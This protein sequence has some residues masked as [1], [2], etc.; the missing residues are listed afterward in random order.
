MFVL[1]EDAQQ[2]AHRHCDVHS[3]KMLL[4]TVQLLYS[5][6]RDCPRPAQFILD[7][8]KVTHRNHPVAMWVRSSAPAYNWGLQYA[9]ALLKE[10]QSRYKKEHK[11][12]PHIAQ[13]RA[14]GVPP[15]V[16]E[17]F[18][19]KWEGKLDTTVLATEVGQA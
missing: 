10:Y 15:S 14:A 12:G 5:A 3:V 18:C 16:P 11:C 13:L 7:P 8:Y 9:E 1:S 19:G 2:S 4:E 17:E 6:W